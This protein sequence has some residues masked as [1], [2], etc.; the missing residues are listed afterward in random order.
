M[1]PAEHYCID[2]LGRVNLGEISTLIARKN[3]IVLH[4]PRQT[5]KTSVLL[6]LQDLLNAEGKYRCLYVNVEAGQAAG[7][8][9]GSAVQT[10]LA[11]CVLQD[12]V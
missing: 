6:A 7:E 5:G 3:Y 12:G 10:L 4:A 11:D 2:P 1:D 8:D 9:T